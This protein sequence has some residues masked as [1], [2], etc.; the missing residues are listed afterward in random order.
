M[1]CTM[2]TDST[3]LL[4]RFHSSNAVTSISILCICDGH[5][6][7]PLHTV[8]LVM[9][10]AHVSLFFNCINTLYVQPLFIWRAQ[11]SMVCS[12]SRQNATFAV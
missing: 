4:A 1:V 3:T 11:L 9:K 5:S 8:L 10:L 7:G 6:F 2:N 12:R